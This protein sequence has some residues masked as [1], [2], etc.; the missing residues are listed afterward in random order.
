MHRHNRHTLTDTHTIHTDSHMCTDTC[1]TKHTLL[2]MWKKTVVL[3]DNDGTHILS[4]N[5]FFA[6]AFLIYPLNSS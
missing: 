6:H 3:S 2:F 5:A 1:Y 4:L